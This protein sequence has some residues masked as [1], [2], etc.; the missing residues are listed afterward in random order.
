MADLRRY[1]EV[2]LVFGLYFKNNISL[3]SN[4]AMELLDTRL[5]QNVKTRLELTGTSP[6]ILNLHFVLLSL[7]FFYGLRM[8]QGYQ[9]DHSLSQRLLKLFFFVLSS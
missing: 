1:C 7:D 5:E 6:G 2:H 4:I 9:L 8:T 3:I